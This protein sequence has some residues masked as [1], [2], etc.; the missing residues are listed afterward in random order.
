[1]TNAGTSNIYAKPQLDAKVIAKVEESGYRPE[2]KKSEG[3][4][5]LVRY[6]FTAKGWVPAGDFFGVYREAIKLTNR[7]LLIRYS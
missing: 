6:I 4:G 1:M 7:T 3:R 5:C 2:I